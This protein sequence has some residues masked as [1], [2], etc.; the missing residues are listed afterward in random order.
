[1][2]PFSF[3]K[4]KFAL[5]PMAGGDAAAVAAIHKT[6]FA[7]SWSAREIADMLAAPANFGDVAATADRKKIGGFIL[8]SLAADEAEVLAIAVD[9]RYRGQ[10]LGKMLMRRNLARAKAAGA[11][12]MFLEVDKSNAA[13]IA[14]YRAFGFQNVGERKGYYRRPDGGSATALIMRASLG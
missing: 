8:S 6:G 12:A 11:A 1:M 13:A 5:S 9:P 14:L 10:G 3:F 4:P 2:G 7:H